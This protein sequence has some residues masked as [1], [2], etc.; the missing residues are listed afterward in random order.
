A[1]QKGVLLTTKADNKVNS[2]TVS[3][4]MLGFEWG[5]PIFITFVRD[6]RF[7][8]QLLDKNGEFTINIPISDI[9]GNI[10]KVCGS[11]SGR[12]TDKLG[13]LNLTVEEPDIISVPGIK[14]LPLTLEC[15]V[16]YTQKQDIN[17]LSQNDREKFYPESAGPDL[18]TAYYGKIV[19]AYI[20]E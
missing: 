15:K 12:D 6:S 4:G 10:T 16:M 5:E 11:K 13:E 2:M 17:V 9:D 20:I 1:L 14:E 19:S 8:K 3:W 7:S 18:H